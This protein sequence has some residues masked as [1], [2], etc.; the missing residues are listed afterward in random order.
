MR[1]T[2]LIL[3]NLW[4]YRR[5]HLYLLLGVMVG[6]AVL[7]GAL[8]IGD[9]LRGSLQALAIDR[10]GKIDFV[11]AP[12]QF[13]PADL[14]DRVHAKNRSDVQ[15]IAPVILL[16][17]TVL[18]RNALGKT[19]KRASGVNVIGI[20]ERFWPLFDRSMKDLGNGVLLNRA[21]A[22]RLVYQPDELVE[23]RIDK[24]HVV[25]ADSIIGRRRDAE[26]LL[27]ESSPVNGILPNTDAGRFS[28][29]TEQRQPLN[30]YVQLRRL[31][32]RLARDGDQL[33]NAANVL[34][35]QCHG[36][37]IQ[38]RLQNDL[39]HTVTPEDYGLKIVKEPMNN[40]FISIESRRMIMD[41]AVVNALHHLKLIHNSQVLPTMTYL[42]NLMM[43]SGHFEAELT[44]ALCEMANPL[45]STFLRMARAATSY[46]PY[47]AVTGLDPD[48]PPP[49][50]PLLGLNGK[51]LPSLKENEI[52]LTEFVVRDLWP[53]GDW[54]KD[55]GKPVIS[56]SY[57]IEGEGHQLRE[58][59]HQFNFVGIVPTG[60]PM[61][62]AVLTPEFPGMR[63]QRI[64]DWKPPFPDSQWHPEW[65]RENDEQYYRKW[66]VAPKGFVS[67]ETAQKLWR[68][69]YGEY[70]S[71]RM[72][73]PDGNVDH[74]I[75]LLTTKLEASLPPSQIGMTFLPMKSMA[76]QAANQGTSSIFGWLFLGFSFFLIMAAL[77]LIGL[78]FRFGV[79]QRAE[80]IGLLLALGF[81]LKHVRRL[82]LTEGVIVSL[83]GSLLGLVLAIGYANALIVGMRWGWQ[84]WLESSFL[85][86]HLAW[87]DPLM[88]PIPYPSLVIGM[89]MSIGFA[90]LALII[91]LKGMTKIEPR[92]LLGGSIHVAQEMQPIRWL[93]LG[94]AL[95]CFISAMALAYFSSQLS[96]AQTASG[97]FF[98]SGFLLLLASLSMWRWWLKRYS[99]QSFNP[100]S[101]WALGQLAASNLG[102]LP[103]RSLLT[104]AMLS[105]GVFMV[106]S[107]QAF[108]KEEVNDFEP[109][110]ATGGFQWIAEADVALPAAPTDQSIMKQ[111]LGDAILDHPLPTSMPV[112]SIV[113]FRLRAGD[114]VSCHNLFQPRKPRILGVPANF[115]A[116]QRF[117]ITLDKQATPEERAEPWRA[118]ERPIHNREPGL[119]MVIPIM[120]DN[121]TAQW[122]LQ[123][124]LG[125]SWFIENDKNQ[126]IKVQLVGLIQESIFQSELLISESHFIQLFPQ[127]AGY[128]YFL[129]E[130]LPGQPTAARNYFD[131]YLG[132]PFGWNVVSTSDRLNSFH[133]V[134]NTY[135]ATFQ[136]LGGMGLLL[137]SAG[138]A[139]ILLRNVNERRAE[140]ALLQALGFSKVNLRNLALVENSWLIVMGLLI[141]VLAACLAIAPR[142][143]Q[144][145]LHALWLPVLML[146]VGII[147]IG[148]LSSWLAIRF[149]MRSSLLDNLRRDHL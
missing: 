13:F 93:P 12:P 103:S 95:F 4:Y 62:N 45:P 63:G 58:T 121:H 38:N 56:I 139:V 24:P 104:V 70:T 116:M 138:L 40:A 105:A 18:I 107:V 125:S 33:P 25:P 112:K 149:A 101:R 77:I 124:S 131:E 7:T 64:Q 39:R 94:F 68:S 3:S 21:L 99:K 120:A 27:I 80:E 2:T 14:A 98:G 61:A 113:G 143:K 37:M 87:S 32:N 30:V 106:F 67:P 41:P 147:V 90:L 88:G 86:F 100:H 141:G 110:G 127:Q 122:I 49:F 6:T 10:L 1:K 23:I 126:P 137:G 50:G 130:S 29:S 35:V 111:M 146:C 115:A 34:L 76:M 69:R 20:D 134:E 142:L 123:K 16:P 129:I 79:E 89:M 114:D 119:P 78:L 15:S 31:Q 47:S 102:R 46:T 71:V 48:T 36:R 128:R 22:D 9:S 83:I 60:S 144:S 82:L 43:R 81:A 42:A 19:Q 108:R 28:L 135:I 74:L 117:T 118:L 52:L 133:T 53:L 11:M 8:L 97:L 85:Q 140:W 54:Q 73:P 55:L 72:A 109:A 145:D 44:M 136:L 91:A 92:Q 17:G 65:V 75:N 59:K 132:E 5:S 96:D 84:G 57:F 148:L 26:G 51:A 66:K